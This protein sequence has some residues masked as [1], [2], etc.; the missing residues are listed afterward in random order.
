MGKK[1]KRPV[2]GDRAQDNSS[3]TDVTTAP[4]CFR[5]Q[6]GLSPDH[7]AEHSHPVISL[8]YPQVV[9]LR[10][11]LLRQISTSS[12]DDRSETQ[13]RGL[14]NLLDSTLVGILKESPPT[15]NQERRQEF[16]AFTQ[17]QS[18]S[19]LT[20][21]DTG[22]PCAQAE[23]RPVDFTT[24]L[25]PRLWGCRFRGLMCSPTYYHRC[26]I[27]DGIWVSSQHLICPGN[28]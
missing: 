6:S 10:Q 28:R 7:P 27:W 22:P 8:Y 21:T 9:T 14:A 16:V 13:L 18:R 12:S 25:P 24:K 11:Y 5:N 20:S 17:S 26:L 23:V 2:K 1:R 19:G 4:T 3:Q 15:C